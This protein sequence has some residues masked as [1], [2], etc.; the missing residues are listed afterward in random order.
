MYHIDGSHN[1][2]QYRSISEV[3][4]SDFT[5]GFSVVDFPGYKVWLMDFCSI[6]ELGAKSYLQQAADCSKP[7]NLITCIQ[8]IRHPLEWFNLNRSNITF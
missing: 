3:T 8:L 5:I 1:K 2:I 4:K 6:E 7:K